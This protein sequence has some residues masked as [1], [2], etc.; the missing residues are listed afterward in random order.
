VMEGAGSEE[1]WMEIVQQHEYALYTTLALVVAYIPLSPPSFHSL[2]QTFY[3]VGTLAPS[4]LYSVILEHPATFDKILSSIFPE[5]EPRELTIRFQLVDLIMV[6]G[7]LKPAPTLTIDLE[8]IMREMMACLVDVPTHVFSLASTNM[9][10]LNTIDS[11]RILHSIIMEYH[12]AMTSPVSGVV[13]SPSSPSAMSATALARF[14]S[15]LITLV[16]TGRLPAGWIEEDQSIEFHG[17]VDSVRRSSV[18]DLYQSARVAVR[19]LPNRDPDCYAVSSATLNFLT[20]LFHTNTATDLLYSS[21]INVLIEILIR[22]LEDQQQDQ[23]QLLLDH[24]LCIASVI[25]S[26]KFEEEPCKINE[27]RS[28]LNLIETNFAESSSQNKKEDET[29]T[30]TRLAIHE[31]A[32]ATHKKL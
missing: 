12:Y 17:G 4:Q 11:K 19:A 31:L 21:D 2:L 28:V 16:N 25:G 6:A 32:T 26:T 23:L 7:Y 8:E 10:L 24:L 1:E 14:T 5:L 18:E 27:I 15:E 29:A 20:E 22:K 3:I 9:L 30:E 13:S